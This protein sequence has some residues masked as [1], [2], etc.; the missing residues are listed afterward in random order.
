MLVAQAV[1]EDLVLVTRD[2]EL[3][4]YPVATLW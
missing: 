4:R 3:G 2:K 1:I